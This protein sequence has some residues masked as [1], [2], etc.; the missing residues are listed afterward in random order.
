LRQSRQQLA[1]AREKDHTFDIL[2]LAALDLSIFGNV[3]RIRQ[4][5]ADG[6]Q[7][8]TPVRA[9][10]NLR[11][12]ETALE[13]PLSP[14]PSHC[15]SGIDKYAIHVKNESVATDFHHRILKNLA[16]TRYHLM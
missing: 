7:A 8:G 6:R 16:K 3:I 2:N 9:A 10:Y 11:G 13:G 15:R 4:V 1:G 5:L 12:I 14:Y